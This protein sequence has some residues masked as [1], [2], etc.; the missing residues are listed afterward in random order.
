MAQDLE[1]LLATLAAEPEIEIDESA[2]ESGSFPPQ[3]YPGR[4]PFIFQLMKDEGAGGFDK[5]P[6]NQGNHL[7]VTFQADVQLPDRTDP[8]SIKY[9]RVSFYK[10]PA[11]ANS[12]GAELLRCLGIGT[13]PDAPIHI[14]N[15]EPKTII[16][17]LQ[18]ADGRVRGE[19]VFGWEAYSKDT[20][21]IITTNPRKKPR[22]KSGKVDIAWPRGADGKYQLSVKFPESGDSAYG[23]ERIVSF[24][25]PTGS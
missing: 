22:K 6:Y 12:D 8:V 15:F 4:H 1:E 18:Q 14:D 20:Q 3:V 7:R 19:A 17:A 10:H 2:P 25:L 21:E 16:T 5:D 23:R 11:M 24:K 13:K 9:Q